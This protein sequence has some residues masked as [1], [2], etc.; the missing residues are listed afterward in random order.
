MLN[1]LFQGNLFDFGRLPS[2]TILVFAGLVVCLFNWRNPLY[3]LPVTIFILWLLLLFGRHTWG[4]LLDVMPFSTDIL[5]FRFIGG[6]HLGGI[7]L[8]GVA[9]GTGWQKAIA[10]S[11]IWYTLIAVIVTLMIL[12]PVFIE[13]RSYV[14]DITNSAR[15]CSVI[16]NAEETD[17]R[18]AFNELKKLPKGRI[19]AGKVHY[20]HGNWGMEYLAGCT[21][22]QTLA[23]TDGLDTMS[24]LYHRY[25]LTSDVLDELDE[26]KLE[27]YNLFN[28]RYVIAPKE[29]SFPDFVQPLRQ[30]GRHHLYRVETSGYFALV[31]SNTAF[32]LNKD[33]F[34][35]TVASW[36]GSDSTKAKQHPVI[37]TDKTTFEINY[38]KATIPLDQD[39][40]FIIKEE[41]G[42][43][44][45]TANVAVNKESTLLLKA[46]YHPN[47]QVTIDGND[48]NALMVMPGFIG[49]RI[50]PGEHIVQ[51]KYQPRRLRATLLILG[52][53]LLPTIAIADRNHETLFNWLKG[54]ISNT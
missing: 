21:L 34:L 42:N 24:S 32:P 48:A 39:R 52:I 45:Y 7:L 8:M 43:N 10:Q 51:F 5:M 31:D 53:L 49:V 6:V 33:D 14:N 47:W 46:S 30:F 25:S 15:Q 9:L 12:L 28:V 27:H 11:N 35:P 16:E 40:G 19:Y 17:L 23:L 41:S 38:A 54:K 26:T 36:L 18:L 3:L 13:R 22:I 20:D 2:L 29:Q 37:S 1:G 50:P 4:N 44:Y